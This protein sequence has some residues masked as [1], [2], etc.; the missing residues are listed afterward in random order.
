MTITIDGKECEFNPGQTVY[1][2]AR[3]NGIYYPGALPPGT[4]QTRGRMQGV[5]G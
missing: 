5:R 3:D 2:V 1:E 4:A